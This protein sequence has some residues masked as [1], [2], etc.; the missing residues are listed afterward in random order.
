VGMTAFAA[1]SI[2]VESVVAALVA[3]G[4]IVCEP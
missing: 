4:N 1:V 3:A 2:V